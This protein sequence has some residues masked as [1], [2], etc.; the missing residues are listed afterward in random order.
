[1]P[2]NK[3]W[4]KVDMDDVFRSTILIVDYTVVSVLTQR[5]EIFVRII[6][7]IWADN[8]AAKIYLKLEECL[9]VYGETTNHPRIK[10]P[11]FRLVV[12]SRTSDVG[13]LNPYW[14]SWSSYHNCPPFVESAAMKSKPFFSQWFTSV[15]IKIVTLVPNQISDI[16]RMEWLIKLKID[17][18]IIS[19]AR[20]S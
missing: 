10:F 15:T 16:T 1:M 7:A 17:C 8:L 4:Y 5:F 14:F 3:A 13:S 2:W 20:W 19:N 6:W 11:K 18:A 9:S 12:V